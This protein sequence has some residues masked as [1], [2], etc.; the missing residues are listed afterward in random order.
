MEPLEMLVV[1]AVVAGVGYSFYAMGRAA[2]G[3]GG[4]SEIADGKI[5]VNA[6]QTTEMAKRS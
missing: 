3:G 6:S 2:F 1:L 4:G 5:H